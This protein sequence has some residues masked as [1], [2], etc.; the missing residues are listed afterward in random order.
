VGLFVVSYF[1]W[2]PDSVR[3]TTSPE[4]LVQKFETKASWAMVVQQATGAILGILVVAVVLPLVLHHVLCRRLGWPKLI[5]APVL[6]VAGGAT[7][8]VAVILGAGAVHEGVTIDHVS[9]RI[10]FRSRSLTDVVRFDDGRRVTIRP[11]DV[12]RIEYVYQT[13]EGAEGPV[14]S[15]ATPVCQADVRHLR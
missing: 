1:F 2:H 14:P 15:E 5:M 6:I 11:R 4:L 8:A 9:Q 10:E 13:N 12:A 7:I 3:R